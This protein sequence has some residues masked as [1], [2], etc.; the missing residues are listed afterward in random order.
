MNATHVGDGDAADA[1][2]NP[3]GRRPTARAATW[4]EL[5]LNATHTVGAPRRGRREDESARRVC[6]PF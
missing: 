1:K 6:R 4:Q 2:M 3:S 5:P